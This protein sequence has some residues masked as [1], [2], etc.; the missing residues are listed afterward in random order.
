MTR[1]RLYVETLEQVVG[2]SSKVLVDVRSGNNVLYLPLDKL[3]QTAPSAQ[4]GCRGAWPR[5]N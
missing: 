5:I 4:A 3:G 1:Q 2:N